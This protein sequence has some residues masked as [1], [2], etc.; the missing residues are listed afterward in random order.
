MVDYKDQP[1]SEGVAAIEAAGAAIN[2]M[3]LISPEAITKAAKVA[4]QA[5]RA[6]KPVSESNARDQGR[7][8]GMRTAKFQNW[9]YDQNQR[10]R[11]TDGTLCGVWCAEFPES[12]ADYAARWDFYLPSVRN[13]YNA[14]RHQ[15]KAPNIRSTAFDLS[16]NPVW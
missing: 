4:A 14:G 16:G 2:R 6:I 3:L 10:W 11:F 15:A 1:T 8:T 9:L 12:K 7:F 5:A 13:E